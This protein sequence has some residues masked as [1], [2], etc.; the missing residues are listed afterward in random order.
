MKLPPEWRHKLN[1]YARQG[2]KTSR[3]RTVQRI[4]AFVTWCGRRPEQIGKRHVHEFLERPMAESTRWDYYYAILV[5]W[6]LLGRPVPPPRPEKSVAL[7]PEK[8]V[9]VKPPAVEA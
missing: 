4:Q 3:L 2:G 6:D 9:E 5:L 7:A 1:Q 8:D